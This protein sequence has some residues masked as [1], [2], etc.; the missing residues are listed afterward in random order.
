MSY[1]KV[2]EKQRHLYIPEGWKLV[3]QGQILKGDMIAE[4]NRLVWDDAEDEGWVGIDVS[5]LDSGAVIRK[6]KC[7]EIVT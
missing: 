2:G 6:I 1:V 3:I 7:G 5:E 4:V